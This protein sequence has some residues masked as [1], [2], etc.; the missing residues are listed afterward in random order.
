MLLEN[1]SQ[2]I[3]PDALERHRDY[4]MYHYE[5]LMRQQN[6]GKLRKNKYDISDD[7]STQY[8]SSVNIRG[9]PY[10]SVNIDKRQERIA[11]WWLIVVND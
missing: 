5:T 8:E 1:L 10:K 2:L 3:T 7:D 11:T 6:D 9:I 4:L